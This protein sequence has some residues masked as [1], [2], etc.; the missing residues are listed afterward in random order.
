MN[1]AV[2]EER[3]HAAIR[4]QLDEC[5]RLLDYYT[6]GL[7]KEVWEQILHRVATDHYGHPPYPRIVGSV[8]ETIHQI[9]A[10]VEYLAKKLKELPTRDDF[11]T[12]Q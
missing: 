9:G 1:R 11:E 2:I 4:P 12:T 3:I 10:A 5:D 8:A 7:P 6:E